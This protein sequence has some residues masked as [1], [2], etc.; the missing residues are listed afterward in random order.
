ME[1]TKDTFTPAARQDS[2]FLA[3]IKQ[4]TYSISLSYLGYIFQDCVS[5]ISHAACEMQMYNTTDKS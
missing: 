4:D 1:A 5:T 3:P 2:C